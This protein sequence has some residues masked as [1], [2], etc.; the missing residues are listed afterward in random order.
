MTEQKNDSGKVQGEM[1]AEY[2]RGLH[3]AGEMAAN[4][5]HYLVFRLAGERF[6]LPT[7]VMR[8]VQRLPKLR[9]VPRVP[10]AILGVI[11]L[12]GQI[13]AVTDLRPLLGLTGR[14]IPPF[15][16]ILVVEQAGLTTALLAEQV[17]DIRRL[18]AAALVPLAAGRPGFPRK[19]ALGQIADES[20]LLILL[21]LP[22]I[23][24]LPER[25]NKTPGVL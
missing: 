2:W 19:A 13:V 22:H 21:N 4:T 16:R 25:P 20:G 24:S 18:P 5:A 14:Q 15:P 17:E 3:A 7:V 9:R 11:N 10:E 1:R 12:R 6:G 8:E 23:L